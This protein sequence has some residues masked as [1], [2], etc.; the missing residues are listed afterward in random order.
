MTDS[1]QRPG[2]ITRRAFVKAG[3]AAAGACAAPLVLPAR[4]FGSQ[5]P[6]NR[7][8]VGQIGTGRIA[9]SHD[10][11]GVIASG[12]ADIVAVCDVDARRLAYG[13]T[14]VGRLS[15]KHGIPVPEVATYADSREMLERS[16]IDAIVIST[17]D[18]SHAELALAAVLAGK[19]VYL[20]K[21]MTM[22]HAEG[23]LLRDATV[24]RRAVMQIG[25]QQRSWG[26]NEQFRKAVELVRSGRV[27]QIRRVELGLP[28]D[29]TKPDDPE[30][31]VPAHL[32]Y[33]RWL[34]PTALV[35][36]T[37]QRVHPQQVRPDGTPDVDSRPGW[38]RNEAYCLGMITGWGT[39]H[40]DTA[41]WG[42]NLELTGPSRIE[43][44]GE[45][46]PR[47]ASG[48]CTA[49]TTSS[50]S[51]RAASACTCPTASR[52][53]SASSATRA[54]SSCRAT[55]RPRRPAIRRPGRRRGSSRSTRATSACSTRRASPC[56][57][58]RA[59]RTTAT[60]SSACGRARRRS[61]R[62]R[63]RTAATARACSAG[64]R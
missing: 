9:I 58:P 63:S 49:R 50:C 27:G 31:P 54:G 32:D 22:T 10:M 36:Y 19:D 17:P 24:R 2:H 47:I 38:L 16:D 59:R 20:Q 29:P 37:E 12:F 23:V 3:A 30:Q 34:G 61:R 35:P 18:H 48:T 13:K 28:T 14:V 44:R 6:S 33:D 1:S 55:R 25:S 8:R 62:R 57:C 56:S 11:P 45:F 53:A 26:P 46:P 60:G 43:G 40:F 41:H 5:A 39:H 51:T 42:M 4:L 64:L 7:I 15:T 52:T 21:P